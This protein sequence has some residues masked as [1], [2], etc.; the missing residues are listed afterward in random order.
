MK[1]HIKEFGKIKTA[2]ID[3]GGLT[4]FVG[5]NNSGKTYLMELIYQTLYALIDLKGI[6]D[7][8]EENLTQ[9][10][11]SNWNI[12]NIAVNKWLK[13]NKNK[14]TKNA[15]MSPIS[16]KELSVDLDEIDGRYTMEDTPD[17]QRV[18]NVVDSFSI[19][20]TGKKKISAHCI[21]IQDTHNYN[22]TDVFVSFVI[23]HT[24]FNYRNN[25]LPAIFFPASRSGL[26]LVFRNV[27]AS[28]SRTQSII[29]FGEKKGKN[30]LGLTRPVYEYLEFLQTYRFDSR[31]TQ[32]KKIVEFISNN[33]VDGVFDISSNAI[34]YKPQYSEKFFPAHL[35][36]SMVNELA[37]LVM[38]LTN[39]GDYNYIFYDEIETCL[40]PLKQ[41]EMARL[42]VRLVNCDYRMIISTHSDTMAIALNNLIILSQTDNRNLKTEKLGYSKE[43][44]F[45]TNNIHIY[46]F[47]CDKA[48]TT[49]SEIEMYPNINIG[50]DFELFNQS[51]DKLYNDARIIME[52]ADE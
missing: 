5:E 31:D 28:Q 10:D 6:S 51:N 41:I 42:I 21:N 47:K 44:F 25:A 26:M 19:S 38:M 43:D 12:V 2:D 32:Q 7:Y 45:K 24:T 34:L 15:F 16:I 13:A 23:N 9:I 11:P 3:L 14:I 35:S 40:H 50:Y 37:P 30:A 33:L 48:K 36:S 29:E 46:Q 20:H 1:I 18:A 39:L 8:F 27:L 22:K 4:V 52:D 49:I 17:T